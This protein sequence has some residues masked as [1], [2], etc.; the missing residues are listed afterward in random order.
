MNKEIISTHLG[1]A[2]VEIGN[3]FWC[4][5][6]E[7][8]NISPKGILTSAYPPNESFFTLNNK[9]KYTP[10]ALY[11]DNDPSTIDQIRTGKYRQLYNPDNLLS[12]KESAADNHGMGYY[13]GKRYLDECEERIRHMAESSDC[14][15]GIIMYQSVG[16]G[17][18]SGM[19]RILGEWMLRDYFKKCKIG[20]ILYPSPTISNS[21]V[22]CYNA[23]LATELLK[24]LNLSIFFDNEALYAIYADYIFGSAVTLRDLNYLIA[25]NILDLTYTI[26]FGGKVNANLGEIV[27][28]LV[29]YH[30]I[31]YVYSHSL[32]QYGVQNMTT[33]LFKKNS[34]YLSCDP[35][36]GKYISS[37]LIYRGHF[38]PIEIQN[39]IVDI[40]SAKEVE[41][42]DW[43]PTGFKIGFNK[44]QKSKEINEL[45]GENRNKGVNMI[46]NSTAIAQIFE[47]ITKKFNL[48]YQKRAFVHWIW[49]YI[50]G[51][52]LSNSISDLYDIIKNHEEVG[53]E[54]APSRQE[55]DEEYLGG[56]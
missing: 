8:H 52:E 16:G 47:N 38:S 31:H 42:V 30:T 22:E 51:G 41:F 5:I 21:V 36:K 33:H 11:F 27:T 44:H 25:R 32:Q 10:R 29:P 39:E 9:D 1:Q 24:C 12:G 28:N 3:R 20:V 7:E 53:I 15:Q 6:S 48:M 14:L 43:C 17:T 37:C 49:G 18:G 2:G 50:A 13:L 26:R 35:S 34:M 45:R 4:L 19:G 46:T 54:T 55:G 40:K 56:G 23:A